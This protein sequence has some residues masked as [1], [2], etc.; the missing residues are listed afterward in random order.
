MPISASL[1][2]KLK[3]TLLDC[4]PFGSHHTLIGVFA[5]DRIAPWENQVSEAEN[6]AQRVDFFVKDFL[7]RKNRAGQSVLVLFLQAIHDQAVE[8]D[9]CHQRLSDIAIAVA[10]ALSTQL[11]PLARDNL[12]RASALRT[13]ETPPTDLGSYGLLPSE[14]DHNAQVAPLPPGMPARVFAERLESLKNKDRAD[15]LPV[16]LPGK[17]PA[18]RQSGGTRGIPGPQNWHGVFGRPGTGVDERPCRPRN[19]GVEQG[20]VRFNVGLQAE[21]QWRYFAEQIVDSPIEELDFALMRL[22]TPTIGASLTLST[23]AAYSSQPANILQHPEGRPMQVALRRNETRF[24]IVLVRLGLGDFD[25]NGP[26]G[27]AV[28]VKKPHRES[29]S[30]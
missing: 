7:D 5:D 15:W 11:P 22:K 29:P 17:R 20:G 23:E 25:K 21:P 30:P 4:G 12:W 14:T 18:G 3:Q 27:H 16:Q 24:Q 19:P 28:V 9:E 26:C 1:L 10:A 13:G 8:D 6:K 2:K